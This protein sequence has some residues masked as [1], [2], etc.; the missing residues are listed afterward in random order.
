M[1]MIAFRNGQPAIDVPTLGRL[2][3]WDD[4]SAAVVKPRNSSCR[5]RAYETVIHTRTDDP[6][7]PC[8]E[9]LSGEQR[10]FCKNSV[11]LMAEIAQIPPKCRFHKQKT[12]H[13]QIFQLAR[14]SL[15]NGMLFA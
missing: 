9:S 15:R 10:A 7:L 4:G 14:P 5:G 11:T 6:V 13:D 12:D 1:G 3:G 2:A 8:H